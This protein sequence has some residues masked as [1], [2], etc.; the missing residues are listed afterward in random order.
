MY[1]LTQRYAV[2]TPY[3]AYE[4]CRAQPVRNC[5]FREEY[6]RQFGSSSIDI[7]INSR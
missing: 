3:R 4:G 7:N 5:E 1:F 6:S 2:T